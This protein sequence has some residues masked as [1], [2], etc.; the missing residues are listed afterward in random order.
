MALALGALIVLTALLLLPSLASADYERAAEHFG[1]G[2]AEIGRRSV[3]I[4]VNVAGDGGV[5]AGSFYVVGREGSRVVRFSAGAEGEPPQFREAWGWGI[6]QGG[7]SNAFVRCGPAYAAE[8]RPAGTFPACTPVTGNSTGGE[9]PGNFGE[10]QGVAVDQATGDVFVLNGTFGR[11]HHLIEVF[12]ADGTP[13]GEGFGDEARRTPL[14]SESIAESPEK[15]HNQVIVNQEGIAVDESGNVHVIDGDFTGVQG[16]Q[17]FRI[18]TFE[19]CVANDFENYC[20]ASGKDIASSSPIVNVAMVGNDRLV[21]AT[22]EPNL[23][24]EYP[25]DG[26]GTPICTYQVPG[27]EVS[28]LTSNPVTGE[29][30]YFS[31]RNGDLHRLSACDETTGAFEELQ[32]GA[33]PSP[34]SEGIQAL[35]FNPELAWGP[36]R[37]PG[38]LYAMDNERHEETGVFGLGDIFVPAQSTPP[39]ILSESAANT[40]ASSSTL[41]ASIDPRGF[42][43]NY[44]FQY[45]TQ[46][47]YEANQPDERQSL[48]VSAT[49]GVFGLAFRGLGLGGMATGN[50]TSGSPAVTNLF[51]AAGTANLHAAKGTATLKGA[52]GKGTVISGSTT[53]TA[54]TATEGSFAGG[55]TISGSGIPAGTTIVAVSGSEM[56]L[57][58]AAT[59]S[60]ANTALSSGTTVISAVTKSEGEYEVG[61]VIEGVGIP[62]KTTITEITETIGTK[63]VLSKPTT[64]PGTGVAIKAGSTTLES[65]ATSEGIFVVGQALAGEGIPAGTTITA[66]EAGDLQISKAPTKPGTGVAITSPGPAPLAVGETVEGVGIPPGTTI[67]SAKAGELTLSQSATATAPGVHIRVGLRFDASATELQEALEGLPTVGTGSVEVFG[68]PGDG[69]GSS[70]Y[71]VAFTGFPNQDLPELEADAS[72]LTGGAASATVATTNNGG[73]GFAHGATEAPIGGGEIPGTG[74]GT[75]SA[76]ISGLSP[77][78]PY[79]FR[80][81]A[82]SECRGSTL[83]PCEVDGEPAAFSTYPE[84]VAGLPDHRAYELVS[85]TRKNGGEAFPAAPSRGSCPGEECK[86]PGSAITEVYPI[87]SAPDGN[88]VAYMGQPFSS[89]EGAAEVDS[90]VSSRTEGGWQTTTM[91]PTI[92]K[93]LTY[94]PELGEGIILQDSNVDQPIGPGAPAGYP[95]L[96]LQSTANPRVLQPLLTEAI[97][98]ALPSHEPRPPHRAES[99]LKL[100]YEGHSPDYSAQY[101]AA[102]DI[103]T[104]QT[105]LAP[106]PGFAGRDL[107][108][109]RQ[110]HLS[111]I[112]VMPGNGSVATGPTFASASPDTYAV[113]KDGNRVFWEA[114][115]HLYVREGGTQTAEIEDPGGFLAASADGSRILLDDGCLYS[116]ATASCTD[117]T[118]GHGGFLGIVGSSED[119]SSV[120]FVDKAALTPEAEAGTCVS[121]NSTGTQKHKEE[122]EGKVPPGLGC[123]LYVYEAGAGTH[124]IARLAARDGAGGVNPDDWAALPGSRTAEASPDGHYLAFVSMAR[125]IGYDNVGPCE[126]NSKAGPELIAA[127]CREVF[128]YDSSTGRLT[129]PSCNPAGEAPSGKSTL[130]GIQGADTHPWLPQPHYLTDQGRLVFDSSER[131]SLSDA[132]G[133][134]EDVYEAEPEGVG[135]CARPLGCISLIS[136][137]TG[138]VDSNFLAMDESGEN[139]FFTSRERLV[140]GDT[141]ELIDVY[142]AREDGGFPAETES[143]RVECQGE[144]CQPV[145]QAPSDATPGSLGFHGAGNVKESPQHK[146]KKHHKKKHHKKKAKS[147]KRT[148]RH[149]RGGTK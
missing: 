133:R 54:T 140:Q 93:S 53:V 59:S 44:R 25:T 105:P 138:S 130:P 76:N 11:V 117:L 111:L 34:P 81:V 38:V 45:L 62:E 75:G 107:Y 71:E 103:F 97:L 28:G 72:G 137:G 9:E 142:D 5:E 64:K 101:F 50:L 115:G 56:T 122:E 131:L 128:L 104:E 61:M 13:I 129:C 40:S 118:Q 121:E 12:T 66:V 145:A 82:A 4:A 134:V 83:P 124:L 143:Q 35:A 112:N 149:G 6:A 46:A 98:E 125:L 86:P 19:P 36:G 27:G 136:P 31:P 127:P 20:Y 63:I 55:Q 24:R 37:P 21:T 106:D 42:G 41:K 120:Y 146:T 73:G 49:G 23:I 68:G 100:E 84:A 18:M 94:G 147:K 26:A 7:P 102:N 57:S 14:P 77:E 78:T 95:N 51:T 116:L 89:S 85:P 60:I 58:A 139:I 65:F 15:L 43:T 48:T 74:T 22:R 39:S 67:L 8:P 91:S 123:N 3:G 96:Y 99:E 148:A 29:V 108:E 16:A 90:Y 135:S 141:D 132:N 126:L 1:V 87:Q 113:S 80:V 88:S 30:F 2:G 47:Q 92:G 69:T 144:S 10:L 52:V 119:L 110:G 79:R 33:R 17:S 109:W 32:A 70:P 114:G